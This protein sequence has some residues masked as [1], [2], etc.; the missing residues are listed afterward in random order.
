MT[1]PDND[2]RDDV[3]T[4]LL[5][6]YD[7]ALAQGSPPVTQ[8]A[9]NDGTL[10]LRLDEAQSCLDFL[11]SAWPRSPST[12]G[13]AS[14]LPT[15]QPYWPTTIGRFE[16]QRELGRGGH[17]VVFLAFDPLLRRRVAL[18]VPRPEMLVTPEMRRRFE[19]EA[20]AAAR[21]DHPN[22]VP[23]HEVGEAGP[24][25]YLVTAY[26]SG[27]NLAAWLRQRVTPLPPVD[28]A[29]L[30][31]QLAEGVAYMHAHGVLH[32]D[33]KPGNI[34]LEFAESKLPI[35][36]LRATTGPCQ[37][38]EITNLQAAIPRL[39][40]F[41]LAKLA[42]D[43][44]KQTR[45]GTVLG[46][47]AY[48]APE[49]ANGRAAL[50]G[51]PTDVYALGAVLYECL[52][53]RPAFQGTTEADTLRQLLADEPVSPRHLRQDVPRDLETICL[54][55]L[56]KEPNRRYAS[57]A[58]LASDLRAFVKG[59]PIAARPGGKWERAAKWMRRHPVVAT[60]L[61][62]MATAFLAIA[63]GS[64]WY[65]SLVRD[66]G[67][68]VQGALQSG[69][70]QGEEHRSRQEAYASQIAQAD[71]LQGDERDRLL[72][73]LLH[74][75]L[76][77]S[78]TQGVRG[79]E[80]HYLWAR[81]LRKP[82]VLRAGHRSWANVQFSSNGKWCASIGRDVVLKIWDVPSGRLRTALPIEI[83]RDFLANALFSSDGTRLF[84]WA[85]ERTDGNFAVEFTLWEVPSGKLL[86]RRPVRANSYN[87]QTASISPDG[88]LVA[89]LG[90][91]T[92]NSSGVTAR[93]L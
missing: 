17:G 24:L 57:A 38:S 28:V 89:Y 5:A 72:A 76:P 2:P 66:H 70:K 48:M 6:E 35:T 71:T 11:E 69:L 43:V 84:C 8:R 21:L 1:C 51:P 83:G 50:I 82:R 54:K 10:R 22:L 67:N 62:S 9:V 86:V 90:T 12:S 4:A 14:A 37:E 44:T 13:L 61:L 7:E 42:E 53:G 25:C 93:P 68:D 18:K 45:T 64:L 39:T 34:L 56:V 73:P 91:S 23:V 47:L 65:A 80:W 87:Y 58:A 40:D 15:F 29:R 27:P 74:A 31:L 30:L 26:C 60:S 55:C 33:I 52:T 92:P 85:H 19:R 36:D 78:D 59:E 75:D 77:G 81:A 41:G 16:L 49:Q 63:F 46:T 3:F 32:R 88:R 79:F 20:E